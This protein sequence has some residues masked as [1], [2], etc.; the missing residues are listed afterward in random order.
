MS[1]RKT[2]DKPA[3]HAWGE[4]PQWLER[5]FTDQKV[6]ASNPHS[7]SRLLLFRFGQ[8]GS[9]SASSFLWLVW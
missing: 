4:M 9:I 6:R 1:H 3:I 8:P 5:G 2:I 7:A